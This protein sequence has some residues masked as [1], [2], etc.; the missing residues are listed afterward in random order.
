MVYAT[1]Q[2]PAGN[3]GDSSQRTNHV[4]TPQNLTVAPSS[5]FPYNIALVWDAPTNPDVSHI[6]VRRTGGGL[7][8]TDQTSTLSTGWA[9][10]R[11][12]PGQTYTFSV[13]FGTSSNASDFGPAAQATYTTPDI[14]AITGLA[15]NEVE[16]D[17][18]RWEWDEP[19]Y[20]GLDDYGIK[21]RTKVPGLD[22]GPT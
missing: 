7:P 2:A 18:V 17:V 22:L 11:L 1:P 19:T 13:R 9:Y 10:N 8:D 21:R 15:I 16:Y 6:N 5:T 3:V 14:P 4:E 20:T 12:K